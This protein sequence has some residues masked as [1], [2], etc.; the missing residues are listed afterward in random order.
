M[1]SRPV[2]DVNRVISRVTSYLGQ[3]MS[4]RGSARAS[5]TG[6]YTKASRSPSKKNFFWDGIIRVLLV[7]GA[8]GIYLYNEC[9]TKY[10]NKIFSSGHASV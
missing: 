5:K 8:I 9:H 4:P 2:E 6:D 10:Y 7:A 1:N 3:V